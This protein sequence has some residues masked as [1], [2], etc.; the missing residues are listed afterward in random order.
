MPP[1]R[2][3]RRRERNRPHERCHVQ[4][5][6]P[7]RR[8]VRRAH[9]RRPRDRDGLGPAGDREGRRVRTS[10]WAPAATAEIHPGTMMYTDG[11]QCTANFVFTDASANVYVG[12]AAHC[13]GLGEAT[14]TNGCAADSL[15]LGTR[16]TFNEGGS[17]LSDGHPGRLRHPGLLLVADREAARHHRREHLRLQRLRPGEGRRRRR[18]Q[19]EPVRPV[20]GRPDRHRHRRHGRRRRRLHLRQLQPPRR[21]LGALAAPGRQPRRRPRRRRLVAPALH[22]DPGRAR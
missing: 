8:R 20:L 16:V 18:R 17:L 14:D 1:D 19:G 11:A 12:Y 9:Q 22:R 15:P 21:R 3:A 6:P 4:V 10:A 5:G 2:T 7:P 13:A